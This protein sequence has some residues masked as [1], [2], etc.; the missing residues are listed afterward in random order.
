M[1]DALKG[2]PTPGRKAVDGRSPARKYT[3]KEEAER[4]IT[5]ILPD[6]EAYTRKLISPTQLEKVVSEKTYRR[7]EKRLI[8]RGEPKPVMVPVGDRRP[9]KQTLLAE[10]DED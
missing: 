4:E 6:E 3:D 7:L 5:L 9:A 8:D 1:D 2:R 10:L